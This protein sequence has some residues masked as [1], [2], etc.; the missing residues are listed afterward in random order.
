MLSNQYI[1]DFTA[2]H[3]GNYEYCYKLDDSFFES[4]DRIELKGVNLEVIIL[5]IKQKAYI[6]L[7]FLI[8]GSVDLECDRCLEFFT[9]KIDEA[10]QMR[11]QLGG[12][13]PDE[14]N[15]DVIFLAANETSINIEPLIYDFIILSL[16]MRRVHPEDAN[17][18]SGCD[19]I[20]LEK[21][22]NHLIDNTL[23]SDTDFIEL[24]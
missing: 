7:S 10:H 20:M 8:K 23:G 16:P 5:L 21:L 11:I 9:S 2:L 6:D 1:V 24:N 15:D 17:G 14:E 3:E 22:N 4:T 12:K 13:A 18:N 19:P